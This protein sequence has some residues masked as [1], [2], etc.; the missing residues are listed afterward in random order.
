MNEE[1]G[2]I[3]GQPKPSKKNYLVIGLVSA[4]ALLF[5]SLGVFVAVN[6][7]I[8]PDGGFTASPT[9]DTGLCNP[10]YLNTLLPSIL[11]KLKCD[12]SATAGLNALCFPAY[13]L[14]I[15]SAYFGPIS[16]FGEPTVN[17][18][19]INIQMD[20]ES[21]A[22]LRFPALANYNG[23]ICQMSEGGLQGQT[24][25]ECRSFHDGMISI[26]NTEGHV[27]CNNYGYF[28]D[29]WGLDPTP[30]P[31]SGFTVGQTRLIDAMLGRSQH[32][33][34]KAVTLLANKYYASINQNVLYSIG[35][36][37][38][39]GGTKNLLLAQFWPNMF[40]GI[41]VNSAPT[42]VVDFLYQF[43]WNL[44][45]AYPT[46]QR[47]LNLSDPGDYPNPTGSVPWGKQLLLHYYVEQEC[48]TLDG[49]TDNITSWPLKCD[50]DV[51]ED[52]PQCPNNTNTPD[53]LTSIEANAFYNVYQG[54]PGD[55]NAGMDPGSELGWGG[56]VS[57]FSN[58]DA[59]TLN[60]ALGTFPSYNV[61]SNRQLNE[62]YAIWNMTFTSTTYNAMI[63]RIYFN[64]SITE[65][66]SAFNAAGGKILEFMAGADGAGT[67][68]GYTSARYKRMAAAQGPLNLQ[69]YWRSVQLPE[70][71]HA[72]EPTYVGTGYPGVAHPTGNQRQVVQQFLLWLDHGINPL[73]VPGNRNAASGIPVYPYPNTVSVPAQTTKFCPYPS[74]ITYIGCGSTL[75]ANNF[76]C[77]YLNS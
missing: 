27:C 26:A 31:N 35:V 13:A 33:M 25:L 66:W 68:M 58:A 24:W 67:G 62:L 38:S 46:W 14:N 64:L 61:D 8:G 63:T 57:R 34:N 11:P 49:V 56:W 71:Y 28:I 22:V 4:F 29:D 60:T 12:K 48:D 45:Q 21:L 44:R 52:V 37:G 3:D 65:N 5:V 53:C 32:L 51:R 19:T 6:G 18:C 16:L 43:S 77:N 72:I 2:L 10:T 54:P 55:N 69:S 40:D 36:G 39:A 23:R 75:S 20:S 1:D 41:I 76:F 30:N 9:T 15:T 7:G 74:R 17:G 59:F 73:N 47:Y 42:T 50:F 70:E